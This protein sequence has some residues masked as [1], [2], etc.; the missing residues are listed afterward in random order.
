MTTS[1][2]TPQEIAQF[3][4]ESG[5]RD[6]TDVVS[7]INES[8]KKYMQKVGREEAGKTL[9]LFM[10]DRESLF[11]VEGL[12]SYLEAIGV[13][14]VSFLDPMTGRIEHSAYINLK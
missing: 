2:N 14:S 9:A 3:Y 13:G 12:A 10:K 11:A 6:K 8:G 4:I 1:Y 5:L 7:L